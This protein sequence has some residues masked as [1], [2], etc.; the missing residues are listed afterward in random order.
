ML[1]IINLQPYIFSAILPY[2]LQP[3]DFIYT[4]P[5]IKASLIMNVACIYLLTYIY[6]KQKNQQCTLQISLFYWH[7]IY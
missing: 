6:K 2:I 3:P 7:N 5:I 4:F 1:L